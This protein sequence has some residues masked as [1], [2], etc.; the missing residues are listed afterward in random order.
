VGFGSATAASILSRILFA[1][2]LGGNFGH[3]TMLLPLARLLRQ[4]GHTLLFAIRDTVAAARLL[5]TQQYEYVPAPRPAVGSRRLTR[6]VGF[7]D[8]LSGAG[9]GDR[10]LLV[11]LTDAWH[12][13]FNSFQADILIAQYAPVAGFSAR[14]TGLP[15]LQFGTG[16]EIPPGRHPYPRPV[17]LSRK[18]SRNENMAKVPPIS[19]KSSMPRTP[20]PR[21]GRSVS[22]AWRNGARPG[23]GC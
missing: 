17:I 9:F 4:R 21:P 18:Q 20:L 22:V 19:S 16:F 10:S 15:C 11:A 3:V 8:I 14:L 23:C 12:Q 1:W 7:A 13:R 6:P 5:A 2:E